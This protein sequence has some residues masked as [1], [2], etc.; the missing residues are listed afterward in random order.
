MERVKLTDPYTILSA[1]YDLVMAHVDYEAWADY[2][3][4]LIDVHHPNPTS[5]VE[6]GCGTGSLAIELTALGYSNIIGTDRSRAMLDV[7]ERKAKQARAEIDFEQIDFR[8]FRRE[9]PADV[10][11]LLY[12]GLNYLLKK[13]EI[14]SLFSSAHDSLTDDGVFI[15]D[16]STPSNSLQNERFFEDQGEQD[17]FRYKRASRYDPETR[18][19]TTTLDLFVR[20][21]RFR[22]EH[23]QLAYTKE[24]IE[25]MLVKAGFSV[26]AAYDGFSLDEPVEES[27]RV[28]WVVQRKKDQVMD[29]GSGG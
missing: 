2:V 19:H 21:E 14:A 26:L 15:F 7:A 27:E 4:H 23:V 25:D 8:D 29:K 10:L 6:L 20:G 12:D 9:P 17:G 24:E 3:G 13:D 1:G 11:L 18:L 22:E 16:Q 5:I 28:H